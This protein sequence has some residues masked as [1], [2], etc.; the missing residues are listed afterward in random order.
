MNLEYLSKAIITVPLLPVLYVQALNVRKK[1]PS[2][3]EAEGPNGL[4]QQGSG[5]PFRLAVL[6]EST[7]AGIGVQT[8]EEGF[9]G[10]LAKALAQQINR[11]I[12]WTIIAK[13]GYTA[14]Q[15]R[16]DLVPQLSSTPYDLIVIGTGGNDAFSLNIPR[17]WKKEIRLLLESLRQKQPHA[18][19]V[20][21][22]MPPIREFPAFPP[23]MQWS[24]GSLVEILGK[25]LGNITAKEDNCWYYGSVI[26]L[27]D[28]TERLNVDAQPSDYFS[29]GVHPSKLT[30]QTWAKDLANYIQKQEILSP[31]RSK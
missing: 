25:E 24:L 22:N 31:G 14:K 2:L 10:T 21:G 26:S 19:I 3:P 1:V 12:D 30:Y 16:Q 4:V 27:Q 23:L 15:I 28:W 7:M 8:H 5:T 9:G 29:D 17:K 13:S 6:G 11:P 20:F 18:P